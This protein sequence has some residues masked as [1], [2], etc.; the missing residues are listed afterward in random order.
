MQPL[1]THEF[2]TV[3][4]RACEHAGGQQAF[5]RKAGLPVSVVCET[6]KGKREPSEAVANAVGFMRR[7]VFVDMRNVSAGRG[8]DRAEER[9]L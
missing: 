1:T 8:S 7:V 3:L 6:L 4:S 2:L 5:A 9:V